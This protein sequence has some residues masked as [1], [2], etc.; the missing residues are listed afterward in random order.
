ML[1][2]TTGVFLS[3]ERKQKK[4]KPGETA[5]TYYLSKVL[6]E[7]DE[8]ITVYSSQEPQFMRNDVVKLV[9]NVLLEQQKV[10]TSFA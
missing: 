9:V 4:A 7:S 6:L 10:Y 5:D 3:S 2:D 1:L 8:S